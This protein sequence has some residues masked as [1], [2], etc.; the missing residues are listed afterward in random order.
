VPQFENFRVHAFNAPTR[1]VGGDFYDFQQLSVLRPMGRDDIGNDSVNEVAVDIVHDSVHE[2]NAAAVAPGALP[3]GGWMGG[4]ADV[5]GKGM[6]AAILSS[7]LLGALSTE[8]RSGTNGPEA[9]NRVNRLLCEKSLPFQFATLFLFLLNP[10]GAGQFISAG[11]N[12]AYLFRSATGKIEKLLSG[13]Y[14]I[15]MF[16]FATYQPSVFHLCA[17]DILFVYSDGL[18]DAENQQQ[19]MFGE[20]KLLDLIRRDAPLGSP[21]LVESLLSAIELFTQGT[22]QTDDI[23]FVVVENLNERAGPSNQ[24][25]LN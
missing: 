21:A 24:G 5:S 20:K 15:G 2:S 11:H 6:P 13:L 10:D 9:L 18:S 8:F 3:S 7:M 16:D 4:L 12:P 14:P 19:E 1:Y 17:S 22:P 23:T 25:K